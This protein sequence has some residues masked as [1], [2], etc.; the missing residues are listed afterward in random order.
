MAEEVV[1]DVDEDLV[2]QIVGRY[3]ADREAETDEEEDFKE[4]VRLKQ[5]MEALEILQLYEEQQNK[6]N[7]RLLEELRRQSRIMLRR[8]IEG[9][10]QKTITEYFMSV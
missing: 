2:D 9:A 1:D 6:G 8:R 7:L 10:E 4:P 5:A 3:G